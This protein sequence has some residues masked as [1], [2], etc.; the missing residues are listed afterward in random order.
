MCRRDVYQPHLAKCVPTESETMSRNSRFRS[1][2]PSQPI[3]DSAIPSR[4]ISRSTII[5]ADHDNIKNIADDN[6]SERDLLDA[7]GYTLQNDANGVGDILDTGA[8]VVGHVGDV[9]TSVVGEV[10]DT[11]AEVVSHVGDVATSV[12]GEVV[13]LVDTLVHDGVSLVESLIPTMVPLP[14]VPLPTLEP[15]Q[16]PTIP[17]PSPIPPIV[18][19]PSYSLTTTTPSPVPSSSPVPPPNLPSS[20]TSSLLPLPPTS[21]SNN[22]MPGPAPTAT[23]ES[24]DSGDDSTSGDHPTSTSTPRP[25]LSQTQTILSSA[26]STMDY[27]TSSG[28]RVSASSTLFEQSSFS[29]QQNYAAHTASGEP[30]DKPMHHG[31][32]L[33]GGAPGSVGG[34][35]NTAKPADPT[36]SPRTP[37]P[38]TQRTAGIAAGTLVFFL[39]LT[40][41]SLFLWKRRQNKKGVNMLGRRLEFGET[42]DAW[43]M[44]EEGEAFA[45]GVAEKGGNTKETVH[46]AMGYGAI[47]GTGQQSGTI[48]GEGRRHL[49]IITPLL[50][51]VRA[52]SRSSPHLARSAEHS[53]SKGTLP[54]STARTRTGTSRHSLSPSPLPSS[55]I[56]SLSSVSLSDE[57]GISIYMHAMSDD[58]EYSP[59]SS[60][61]SLTM[62]MASRN[63][64]S[65]STDDSSED[66]YHS[67]E[68]GR[69]RRRRNS[70]GS[71]ET[72]DTRSSFGFVR[73][74]VTAAEGTTPS[75]FTATGHYI[76]TDSSTTALYTPPSHASSSLLN[77]SEPGSPY[78][79]GL[80]FFTARGWRKSH[81]AGPSLMEVVNSI[82]PGSGSSDGNWNR[83]AGS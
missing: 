57:S 29:N 70:E 68:A 8:E 2:L 1:G 13:G 9:A 51:W 32:E 33:S 35:S 41:I 53:T 71:E 48:K 52:R 16:I 63:A 55:E 54:R 27:I 49:P 50:S 69:D 26:D 46:H 39:F 7:V 78:G 4:H 38:P 30:G 24:S 31:H 5:S 21:F 22:E 19:S 34:M 28:T 76:T 12:V 11:G 42:P 83:K 56:A 44:I 66:F 17:L 74:V 40:A 72:L 3:F 47:Q 67:V 36:G 6:L 65:V 15:S 64:S 37:S 59:T 25:T 82:S 62:S 61:R 23:R 75:I 10:L 45:S 20:S 58:D 79:A 80:D 81:S 73:P 43:R 60:P 14:T 18:P 77:T